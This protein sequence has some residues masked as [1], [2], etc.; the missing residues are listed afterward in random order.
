M[1]LS[2]GCPAIQSS[3]A[4]APVPR[5]TLIQRAPGILVGAAMWHVT[6]AVKVRMGYSPADAAGPT[7]QLGGRNAGVIVE[8]SHG[9]FVGGT[10]FFAGGYDR[11]G[12]PRPEGM[13]AHPDLKLPS[14]TYRLVFITDAPSRVSFA[15]LGQGARSFS[16]SRWRP[17]PDYKASFYGIGPMDNGRAALQQDLP[18]RLDKR[19][20]VRYWIWHT[21]LVAQL[22]QSQLCLLPHRE[23][24]TC[25]T[26]R[27]PDSQPGGVTNGTSLQL[28]NGSI[29]GKGYAT[30]LWDLEFNDLN[31]TTQTQGGALTIVKN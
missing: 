12:F 25:G 24:G 22:E 7:E 3:A 15:I 18:F 8:D 20:V 2:I 6:S 23:R 19:T 30:G 21:G 10:M 1:A 14:G 4:A 26:T 9:T 11:G 31:V 17:A 5:V 13:G 27:A 28:M 16:V 29:L